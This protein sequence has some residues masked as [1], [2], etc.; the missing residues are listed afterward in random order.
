LDIYRITNKFPKEE[1]YGLISQ[2][3][4]SEVERMFKAL[5]RSLENKH[6]NP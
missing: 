2:A 5:I 1:R 6:L 3:R 4:R